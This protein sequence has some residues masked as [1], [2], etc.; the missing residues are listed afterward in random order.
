VCVC[1]LAV[2]GLLGSFTHCR[3]G[4][5]AGFPSALF[6]SSSFYPF[7][8]SPFHLSTVVHSHF[9]CSSV[10]V[11]SPSMCSVLL[12]PM[13]SLSMTHVPHLLLL[14]S[15]ALAYS[16]LPTQLVLHHFAPH[17]FA[18]TLLLIT[19]LLIT[20]LLITLLLI[21]P[22][23]SQTAAEALEHDWIAQDGEKISDQSMP[24]GM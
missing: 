17:H 24:S 19:L 13:C 12:C 11:F 10:C 5:Q 23:L 15:H 4:S 14:I 1:V 2:A 6:L 8:S 18:I 21:I 22:L 7:V 3:L 9:G 20:L 16:S